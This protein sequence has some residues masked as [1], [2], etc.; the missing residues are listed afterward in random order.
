MTLVS[1]GTAAKLRLLGLGIVISLVSVLVTGNY[2]VNAVPAGTLNQTINSSILS[3]D[4]KDALSVS[5]PS[6]SFTLGATTI[7]T[8]CQTTDGIY[9]SNAER[10][11]VD[12]PGMAND[13]WSLT[14]AATGGSGAKWTAG[15]HN[16]DYDDP[17]GSGCTNGQLSLDPSAATLTLE[18]GAATGITLGSADSFVNGS[19]ITLL[20]GDASSDNFW[21]GYLTGIEL[22]QKIPASTPAGSYVLDLTQTITNL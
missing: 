12:N 20:N 8:Y 5:V 13:G 11:Y 6:P 9:G 10:I 22:S 7:T 4:I 14:V 3:T 16:Y 2:T 19:S 21:R 17:S 15:A 18:T 1:H